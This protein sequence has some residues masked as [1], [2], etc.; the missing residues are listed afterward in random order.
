MK[1]SVSMSA[2]FYKLHNEE[3]EIHSTVFHIVGQ[4]KFSTFNSLCCCFSPPCHGDVTLAVIVKVNTIPLFSKSSDC[5]MLS[6]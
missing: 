2:V 1:T 6:R 4:L 5:W 3:L